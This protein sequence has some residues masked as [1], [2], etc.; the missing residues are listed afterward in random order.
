LTILSWE[1]W[2]ILPDLAIFGDVL[3][4]V[5]G[6]GGLEN[7]Q[8]LILAGKR[9]RGL[10]TTPLKILVL[11]R[12]CSRKNLQ[13]K[14]AGKAST[15]PPSNAF[16]YKSISHIIDAL[17]GPSHLFLDNSPRIAAFAASLPIPP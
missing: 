12:A 10:A 17:D 4:S 11:G 7:W 14:L 5:E 15:G 2:N 6:G 1:E 13:K 16:G 9:V 3:I 8:G